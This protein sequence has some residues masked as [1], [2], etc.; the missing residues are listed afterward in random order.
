MSDALAARQ[1]VPDHYEE[2]R[3]WAW[4][5]P[6]IGDPS[7]P[8]HPANGCFNANILHA[9]QEPDSKAAAARQIVDASAIAWN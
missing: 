6:F 3:L 4:L 7:D 1:P 2:L 5:I 9:A 8:R